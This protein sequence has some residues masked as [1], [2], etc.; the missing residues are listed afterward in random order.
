MQ[1][2][3]IKELNERY[4]L[5]LDT[6]V[7]EINKKKCKK[8][9]LQFAD[10]LKPYAVSIVDYL[11]EK[12]GGKIEFIIWFGTCFGSCDTPVLPEN[13]KKEIDLLIQFGHNEMMPSY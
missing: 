13:I 10:G 9:L 3:S 6:L 12:T 4:S 1:Q 11:R 2:F 8:V 5:D 7:S